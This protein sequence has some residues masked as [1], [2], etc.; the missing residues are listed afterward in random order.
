[1][2][3]SLKSALLPVGPHRVGFLAPNSTSLPLP[4]I[5]SLCAVCGQLNALPTFGMSFYG[6]SLCP[7]GLKPPGSRSQPLVLGYECC[8]LV[9]ITKSYI[10]TFEVDTFYDFQHILRYGPVAIWAVPQTISL[11]KL[12]FLVPVYILAMEQ[13]K[14][15]ATSEPAS[16]EAELLDLEL[17]TGPRER[18]PAGA[19]PLPPR[20]SQST[21]QSESTSRT[22]MSCA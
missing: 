2:L 13:K 7:T 4:C 1:M 8:T 15:L 20:Q 21:L 18:G 16:V 17:H 5:C 3:A 11:F 6:G 19:Q 9:E 12:L 14:G 22:S 10:V